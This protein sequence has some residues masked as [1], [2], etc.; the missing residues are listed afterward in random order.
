MNP[1]TRANRVGHRRHCRRRASAATDWARPKIVNPTRMPI[2][3]LHVK[4]GSVAMSRIQSRARTPSV[5]APIVPSATVAASDIRLAR[6]GAQFGAGVVFRTVP[7]GCSRISWSFH[8]TDGCRASPG[9]MGA[10]SPGNGARSSVHMY[11]SGAGEE[12]FRGPDATNETTT[13][14]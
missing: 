2:V 8:P 5:S 6:I 9:D 14:S 1:A 12:P 13:H 11:A 10:M 7:I 4:S 3:P